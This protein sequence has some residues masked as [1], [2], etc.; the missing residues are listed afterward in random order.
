MYPKNKVSKLFKLRIRLKLAYKRFGI[1]SIDGDFK[2]EELD[3]TCLD[4]LLYIEDCLENNCGYEKAEFR[5]KLQGLPDAI[6]RALR[7]REW[8]A[9]SLFNE[10]CIVCTM[11]YKRGEKI[12]LLPCYHDYHPA[13]I[14]K[15][16]ESSK[17]C[18]TCNQEVV[19]PY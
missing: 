7:T 14:K 11:E 13:C 3:T 6:F 15:W 9:M 12:V 16:F 5:N 18:P 17:T 19:Y 10:Q 4:D 8:H 2:L 1:Q